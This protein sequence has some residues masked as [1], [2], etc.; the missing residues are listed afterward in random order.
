L[1]NAAMSGGS[2]FAAERRASDHGHQQRDDKQDEGEL[3]SNR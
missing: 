1:Y 3:C 2:V